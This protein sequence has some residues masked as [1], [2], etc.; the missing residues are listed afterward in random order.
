MDRG[1]VDEE[2]VEQ[3]LISKMYRRTLMRPMASMGEEAKWRKQLCRTLDLIKEG[4]EEQRDWG[5]NP[6]QYMLELYERV[7]L[8]GEVAKERLQEAQGWQDAAYQW[9][10]FRWLEVGDRL[11]V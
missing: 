4:W 11:L 8:V 3:L 6:M 7:K 1:Q 10:Q 2:K 5:Q 9:A